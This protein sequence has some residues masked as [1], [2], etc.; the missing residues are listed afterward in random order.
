MKIVIP[1]G[2][3]QAGSLLA[4]DLHRK[5]HEVIVLS[6]NKATAAWPILQWDAA[7]LGK[8]ASEIEGADAVINLAGRSVNCRYTLANRDLIKQS[9]VDS[10]KVIAEAISK[11][12]EPPRVW[13]QASTATNLCASLRRPK[14]RAL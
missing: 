2:S 10:T 8:W 11:A 5:G 6:G 14:R 4:R 1:G 7:T 13:L 3:G 12:K 9:R